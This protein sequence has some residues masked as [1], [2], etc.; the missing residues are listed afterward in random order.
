VSGAREELR[1][2]VK[3]LEVR[4]LGAISLVLERRRS[5]LDRLAMNRAF[6]VAPNR[7][8]EFLQLFDEATFRL[9]QATAQ[10]V[11]RVG[12]RCAA[13]AERLR[14]V[15]LGRVIERKRDLLGRETEALEAAL[16]LQL[17]RKRGR[18]EVEAGR[19]NALSPLAILERG[20]AICRD[21]E[22]RILRE[23]SAL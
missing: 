10:H 2:R 8:R 19:L 1:G 18:L 6:N 3:S 5:S 20:Y 11:G 15:D 22:G 16:G 12:H 23:A 14:R 13:A 4:L 9:T 7:L 17:E 21:T